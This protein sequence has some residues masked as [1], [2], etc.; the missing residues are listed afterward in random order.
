M[1]LDFNLKGDLENSAS[2]A[3]IRLKIKNVK[4]KTKTRGGA[5]KKKEKKT[6]KQ[7]NKGALCD[8]RKRKHAFF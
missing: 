8:K 5:K 4:N 7:R 2:I 1:Y 6:K 3:K